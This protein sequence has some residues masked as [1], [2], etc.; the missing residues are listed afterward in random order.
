M[1]SKSRLVFLL[2]FI[3]IFVGT[4]CTSEKE[5]AAKG[6]PTCGSNPINVDSQD[7]LTSEVELPAGDY[8]YVESRFFVEASASG[9]TVKTYV[10]EFV[11]GK[12]PETGKNETDTQFICATYNKNVSYVEAKAPAPVFFDKRESKGITYARMRRFTIS[13]RNSSFE[14]NAESDEILNT[15]AFTAKDRM[16]AFYDQFDHNWYQIDNG[17]YELRAGT[18]LNGVKV[19]VSIVF[20]REAVSDSSSNGGSS[21]NGSGSKGQIPQDS[22]STPA[23]QRESV[24]ARQDLVKAIPAIEE[25]RLVMITIVGSFLEGIVV[26]SSLKATI[27]DGKVVHSVKKEATSCEITFG[28]DATNELSKSS[29]I[30]SLEIDEVRFNQD[31]GQ[32]TMIP[33]SKDVIS[34]VDC[35]TPVSEKMTEAQ[36]IGV[37]GAAVAVLVP[38]S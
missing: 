20:E 25:G 30:Y 1:V 4:A 37:L 8:K 14:Y 3:F 6:T 9:Q 33:K 21:K 22:T 19:S 18:E 11:T 29:Y 28:P 5:N 31:T 38:S 15:A 17:K 12:D 32:T 36:L 10:R 34:E 13:Y 24:Q 35:R 26:P 2:S 16:K 23:H 27:Q 7:G